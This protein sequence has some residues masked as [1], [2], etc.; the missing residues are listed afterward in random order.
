[1]LTPRLVA[2]VDLKADRFARGVFQ[3]P[4]GLAVGRPGVDEKTLDIKK[5]EEMRRSGDTSAVLWTIP[6]LNHLVRN[7]AS[8][9]RSGSTAFAR[10][11]AP[12]FPEP[13]YLRWASASPTMPKVDQE[14]P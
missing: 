13:V 6:W 8:G 10:K 1:M 7:S 12:N 9:Q 2:A 5:T 14:T 4:H 11:T 3:M